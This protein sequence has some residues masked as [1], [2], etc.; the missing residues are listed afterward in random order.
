MNQFKA[1][2]H[3]DLMIIPVDSIPEGLPKKNNTELLEG[4]TSGHVHRLSGG[5]VYTTE[6]TINNNFLLGYFTIEK[7]TPLS[8]EEHET[9]TLPACNYKFIQ[10]REYDPQENRRVID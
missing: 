10:Q 6:P 5:T 3:G 9:I 2:R 4:E 8:H 7:P 1:Y